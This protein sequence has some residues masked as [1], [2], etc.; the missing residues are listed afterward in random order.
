MVASPTRSMTTNPPLLLAPRDPAD[1]TTAS[2]GRTTGCRSLKALWSGRPLQDGFLQCRNFR[3]HFWRASRSRAVIVGSQHQFRIVGN[4][5]PG[6]RLQYLA[7]LERT[8]AAIG[9]Q[10]PNIAFH[11]RDDDGFVDDLGAHIHCSKVT[12]LDAYTLD[13][14][15]SGFRCKMYRIESLASSDAVNRTN[16]F[17]HR[18][19]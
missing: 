9:K 3:R 11:G 16:I 7:R 2:G 6:A 10:D 5:E 18:N 12:D 15:P 13:A 8:A 4:I 1:A 17:T 19:Q 14:R